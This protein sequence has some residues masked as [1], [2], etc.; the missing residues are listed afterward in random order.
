M[1]KAESIFSEIVEEY[2]EDHLMRFQKI[3]SLIDLLYID[4]SRVYLP[5]I[6]TQTQNHGFLSKLRRLE[7]L[8]EEN[9]KTMKSPGAYAKMMFLSERHLNRICKE[10]LN[11][12]TSDLIMDKIMLEAKRMLAQTQ[13]SISEIA[14]EL[15]YYD[16]SYFSRLFK[17]ESGQ[18]PAEFMKKY[19]YAN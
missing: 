11:K 14:G 15:G 7:D 18:T 6:K 2:K 9:F 17:R 5:D 13:L 10:C 16:V 19:N 3:Y 4:L 8:I 1:G 12:T